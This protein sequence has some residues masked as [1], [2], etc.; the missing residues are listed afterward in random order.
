[1][2]TTL[3][4]PSY[5]GAGAASYHAPVLNLPGAEASATPATVQGLIGHVGASQG[6]HLSVPL[7]HEGP[8]TSRA[9]MTLM[10]HLK[11]EYTEAVASK[12][13]A[14]GVF[15]ETGAWVAG[16]P[17]QVGRSGI[18][19][20]M[21]RVKGNGHIDLMVVESKYG[22]SQLGTTRRDGL[23]MSRQWTSRRLAAT[24]RDYQQMS[25]FG[26]GKRLIEGSNWSRFRA[27]EVI[28]VPLK[29]GKV[30][31]VWRSGD[32]MCYRSDDPNVTPDQ[33]KRKL[34]QTGQVL[35]AAAHGKITYRS[36]IFRLDAVGKNHRITFEHFDPDTLK[37]TRG[38]VITGSFDKLP[39]DIQDMLRKTFERQFRAL[40]WSRREARE[41]AERACQDAEFYR[42]MSKQPHW[43]LRAGL[44]RYMLYTGLTAGVAA[45][46]MDAFFQWIFTGQVDWKRSAVLGVIG[47]VAGGVG[48]Y[49]GIQVHT[50]LVTTEAGRRII[51][52]LPSKFFLHRGAAAAIGGLASGVVASAILAYGAYLLGY[53]DLRSANRQMVAGGGAL[54]GGATFTSGAMAVAMTFG[55]ASTGTAI[56]TLS[57]A[58][59][60]NAAMAWL[61]GGAAY[62]G[63][64]GMAGGAMVL[65]GGAAIV[66]VALGVGIGAAF[67]YMDKVEQRR[68][69]EGRLTLVDRHVDRG[70]QPEWG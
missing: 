21:F 4:V 31:E 68:V 47:G 33:I 70:S 13:L 53:S 48:Y 43:S 44:D 32:R 40:G 36:R 51:E 35:E 29:D 67:K 62:A 3:R 2:H 56:S 11:G 12:M 41:L 6:S 59:A 5:P 45:F 24:A 1:M 19:G 27:K 55:T 34:A 37:L 65:S 17:H 64:F 28:R 49:V 18:D 52:L 10:S 26:K 54:L 15:H 25:D 39:K 38:K 61:G 23:Q 7:L 20:L 8:V 69:L 66:A 50:F 16:T 42:K 46:G 22:S 30:A 60:T 14:G 58:A 57:G 63:G 9:E